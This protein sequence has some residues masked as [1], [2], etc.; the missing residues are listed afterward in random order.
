[1]Y[2]ARTYAKYMHVQFMLKNES[3]L[4]FILLTLLNRRIVDLI[5]TKICLWYTLIQKIEKS[6]Q[7]SK[8]IELISSSLSPLTAASVRPT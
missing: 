6:K 3:F 8:Q 4:Y 1:M 7:K 2:G 5:S